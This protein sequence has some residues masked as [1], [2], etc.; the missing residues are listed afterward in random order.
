MVG[1]K[2]TKSLVLGVLFIL[3]ILIIIY[4][5]L[6]FFP[7]KISINKSYK[8]INPESVKNSDTLLICDYT[9]G[10]DPRWEVIGN[11]KGLFICKDYEPECIII[12]GNFSYRKLNYD[13]LNY[14]NRF[15]LKGKVIGEEKYGG[16]SFKVFKVER[17]DVLYPIKQP[18]PFMPKRWLVK[19]DYMDN[20]PH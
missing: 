7:L 5:S 3:V 1:K 8:S 15:I 16:G 12:K 10:P 2:L 4:V 17:W 11:N 13:I 6:F 20:L 9:D 18:F 14:D 19:Y